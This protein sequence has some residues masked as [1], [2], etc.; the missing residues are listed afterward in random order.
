MEYPRKC[1]W[2]IVDYS[3]FMHRRSTAGRNLRVCTKL[4]ENRMPRRTYEFLVLCL[5]LEISAW[6][7]SS[8]L[9]YDSY[10]SCIYVI[11]TFSSGTFYLKFAHNQTND[12]AITRNL[13]KKYRKE[14]LSEASAKKQPRR[15][16]LV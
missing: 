7:L 3:V 13:S 6:F 16:F 1:A 8:L 2:T 12:I 14:I 4:A 11:T 5:H 10:S 15:C 9:I